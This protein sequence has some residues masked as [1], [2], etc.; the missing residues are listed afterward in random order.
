MQK[1]KSILFAVALLSMIF[2]TSYSNTAHAQEQISSNI[3]S[4][5]VVAKI[6][7]FVNQDIVYLA[8]KNQNQKYKG[9]TQEK[10]DFLD[11]TWKEETKATEKFLISATL[12]NPLSAYLTRVQAHSKGLYTEMFVMDKNGLNVGQSSIT[13]DYWQGDEGKFQKTYLKGVNA[14]FI[15]ESEYD[16]SLGAW[17]AQVNLAVSDGNELLG[18]ITIE[19]NLSELKRR[20]DLG[21]L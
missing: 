5:K 9:I 7:E 18:A 3:I 1:N 6:K 12:S 19:V 11:N 21:I 8:T 10:I 13:S 2:I 14:I 17:V 15:D 4:D 16:D 20:K